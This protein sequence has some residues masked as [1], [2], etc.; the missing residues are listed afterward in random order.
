MFRENLEEI[1]ARIENA[2]ARSGRQRAEI[3]LLAVSKTFQASA[4][5]EAYDAGIR[6]FGENYIQEFEL[7]RPQLGP[8]E[9]VQFH[10]I[11]HLQ[12][13]KSRKAAELFQAVQTVDSAKLARRL[14]ECG[15]PLAVMIEVKLSG[16]ESKHGVAPE[17]IESLA[18]AIREMPNLDLQGLMTMPPWSEDQE[19]SRPYFAR[20]RELALK[21]N[22][23]K[24]SMGMSNDF[25]AAIEEGA[26]HVRIGTALFGSRKKL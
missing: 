6:D 14:S 10:L 24:L 9:D 23:P 18:A 3:T 4:L 15:R 1:H 16:E 11:G 12:S 22:L 5:I 25:E 8:M 20:L 21:H 7:K 26:T 17:E 2:A 13:N 19:K